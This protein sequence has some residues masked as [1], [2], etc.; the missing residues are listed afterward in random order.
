MFADDELQP[1][2]CIELPVGGFLASFGISEEIIIK[3]MGNELI[4]TCDKL[5]KYHEDFEVGA[6]KHHGLDDVQTRR[7]ADAI[8]Y[9]E[10][11][12]PGMHGN[13]KLESCKPSLAFND[14]R[15]SI[16]KMNCDLKDALE[17]ILV[18]AMERFKL[19]YFHGIINWDTLIAKEDTIVN[20]TLA[21]MDF[22]TVVA[23]R[24]FLPYWKMRRPHLDSFTFEEY[25]DYKNDRLPRFFSWNRENIP[26]FFGKDHRFNQFPDLQNAPDE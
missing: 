7:I 12:M 8:K 19:A 6:L 26:I 1:E 2:E 13:R 4:D 9:M 21:K 25:Q 20:H 22:N 23:L 11:E 18:S 5:V 14:F 16:P 3:L 10:T 24:T 15:A 17:A